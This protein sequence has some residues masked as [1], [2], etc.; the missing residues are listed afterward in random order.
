MNRL[1]LGPEV[2]ASSTCCHDSLHFLSE[3]RPRLNV[4]IEPDMFN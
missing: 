2:I 4:Q 3:Q 1:V